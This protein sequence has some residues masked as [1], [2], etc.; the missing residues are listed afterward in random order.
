MKPFSGWVSVSVF[1]AFLLCACGGNNNGVKDKCDEAWDMMK[2]FCEGSEDCYPCV[3]VYRDE[4]WVSFGTDGFGIPNFSGA[5]CIS[6]GPCEGELLEFSENCF[7]D[8]TD[9]NPCFA[10]N[11]KICHST[12]FEA[13]CGPEWLERY[14]PK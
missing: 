14:P 5:D 10:G 12:G 9:C 8:W 13:L 7:V 4:S 6:R 3:C 1:F 11:F 2:E